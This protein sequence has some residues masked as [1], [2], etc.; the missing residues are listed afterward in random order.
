MSPRYIQSPQ[1]LERLRVKRVL[2]CEI[3]SRMQPLPLYGA[4][5]S[6]GFPSPADDFIEDSLDL[7]ELLIRHPAA[8]FFVRVQGDSMVD[9][10]IHSGDIL[11]VDRAL[12]PWNR[13]VV[14]AALNGELIVKRIR[15]KGEKVFLEPENH[16]YPSIE[17]TSDVAFRIWGVVIHVIHSLT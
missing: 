11:I 5:V 13:A 17:V 8:T 14:V 1:D 6:A 15:Q 16:E 10:G 3:Y 4:R 12:E 7:N 2:K 9:A